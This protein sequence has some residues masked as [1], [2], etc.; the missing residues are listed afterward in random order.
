MWKVLT[1]T[2]KRTYYNFFRK[3]KNL[4]WEVDLNKKVKDTTFVVIDTETTGLD[5]KKDEVISVGAYK[6]VDLTLSFSEKLNLYL[7]TDLCRIEDSIK[8]HG[9]TP[10]KLK[11]GLER[12]EALHQFLEF[13]K[14]AVL[15]GYFLEFDLEMLKKHLKEELNLN[16]SF[17]GFDVLDLYPKK[18]LDRIPK[19]NELLEEY[20]LPTTSFHNALEDAYMTALLFLKLV[21]SYRNKKLKQLPLKII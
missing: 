21:Y 15:V 3:K 2:L 16:V 8:I 10:D 18:T 7:K 4:S 12:K 20:D 14:G 6:I 11:N 9:I 1:T 17:Y 19:L 13:T 5:L